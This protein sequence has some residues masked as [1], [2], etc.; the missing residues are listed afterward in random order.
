MGNLEK[1]VVL[2]VL[3]LSAILLA[4][5]VTED[6]NE[7][8]GP[9]DD[10][11][12]VAAGNGLDSASTLPPTGA[13]PNR[14]EELERPTPPRATDNRLSMREE[15]DEP[16]VAPRA[17]DPLAAE[18]A[19]L[20]PSED[21]RFLLDVGGD[22]TTTDAPAAEAVETSPDGRPRILEVTTGLQESFSPLYMQYTVREGDTWSG[23]ALRFYRNGTYSRNL[24]KDNEGLEEL[25]A[26]TRI[27]IPI[28]DDLAAPLR[29]PTAPERVGGVA[30]SGRRTIKTAPE[31]SAGR[32][33]PASAPAS[34]PSTAGTAT[35]YEV[36]SGDTLSDISKRLY[37][38]ASLWN[39]IFEAN[40]DQ[41]A[42]PHALK[43]GMK[44]VIPAAPKAPPTK[45]TAAPA[46]KKTEAPAG[47]RVD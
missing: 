42:E 4:W 29:A 17:E 16:T 5:S 28:Y 22:E 8:G 39:Q 36:K 9:L 24:R 30:S 18:P 34:T 33:T 27:L 45:K 21:R 12:V 3:F 38:R 6:G 14:V 20:T 2:T 46:A 13:Q 10:R 15:R 11:E 41:L 37:G 47:P 31:R 19:G 26:G 1:L 35:R 40:R 7:P 43:V 23:L 25:V 32:T 44:L